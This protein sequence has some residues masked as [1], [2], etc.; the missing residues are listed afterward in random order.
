MRIF[1]FAFITLFGLGA[2]AHIR[3]KTSGNL[4]PRSTSDSL[5]SAPCGGVARA[6]S[7]A[8]YT[9]GQTITMTWEETINH[10]GRFEISFSPAGDA[11]WQLLKTIPDTMDNTNDLP[12]QY[13]TTVTLPN[14]PCTACTI[15]LIQVMT[16]N[17]MS[18]TYY[19]SCSDIKLQSATLTP[20]TT[21]PVSP[22]CP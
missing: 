3:A 11:N 22:V 7:S 2:Q 4:V 15:Q 12:H 6:L 1:I 18:P 16:E 19:Y 8:T 10:P 20:P 21:T 17:P 14:T 9:P 13:S 5:K